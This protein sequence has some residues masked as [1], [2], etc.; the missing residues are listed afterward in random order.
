M[1]KLFISQPMRGLTDEEILI[2]RQK[3]IDISC[4]LS[5]EQF[6]IIQSFVDGR[7]FDEKNK[8]IRYLAESIM[9]LADA[10]AAVFGR[11]WGEARGCRIEHQICEDYG[12]PII[13]GE[14]RA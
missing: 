1:K 7:N 14:E 4:Q 5:G 3:I 9:L 13:E 10:D 6:E 11:G 8:P 12:I 2:E